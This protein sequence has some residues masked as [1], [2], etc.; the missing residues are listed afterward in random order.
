MIDEQVERN[1]KNRR[2]NYLIDRDL[3]VAYMK[4]AFQ[5]TMIF[6]ILATVLFAIVAG[7][8]YNFFHRMGLTAQ[9][10]EMFFS[11]LGIN[12]VLLCLLFVSFAVAT[13]TL[14]MYIS[15]RVAGPAFSYERRLRHLA[16]GEFKEPFISRKK[17]ELK[18]LE[19]GFNQYRLMAWQK[20]E[21]LE[22]RRET[23]IRRLE[24]LSS[25]PQKIRLKHLL[26]VPV[27]EQLGKLSRNSH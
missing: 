7:V 25:D 24:Q 18:D 27:V 2:K 21:D 5:T 17:D 26:R 16:Q 10:R 23:Y 9:G 14:G 3:Q 11:H 15:H 22:S 20:F 6:S 1:W 13:Y 19:Y 8:N 12:A 4:F